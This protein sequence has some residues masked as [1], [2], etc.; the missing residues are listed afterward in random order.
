MLNWSYARTGEK[1][2]QRRNK[3]T[4]L[5]EEYAR[6]ILHDAKA[7]LMQ[8]GRLPTTLLILGMSSFYRKELLA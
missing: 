1:I 3:D 7:Y 4:I 8:F 6:F 5:S 2:E